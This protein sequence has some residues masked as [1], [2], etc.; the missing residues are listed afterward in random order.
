[1]LIT[2]ER[3]GALVSQSQTV[4]PY[5]QIGSKPTPGQRRWYKKQESGGHLHFTVENE[6]DITL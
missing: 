5:R 1:M 4:L 3:T 6:D 2:P